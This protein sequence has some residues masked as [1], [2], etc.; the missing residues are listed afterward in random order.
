MRWDGERSEESAKLVPSQTY[1]L[2]CPTKFLSIHGYRSSYLI[3]PIEVRRSLADLS[4][5]LHGDVSTSDKLF[6]HRIADLMLTEGNGALVDLIKANFE[7]L[8][9]AGAISN[10]VPIESGF[11]LFAAI[12]KERSNFLY[13]DQRS[14][15]LNGY[16]DHIRINLINEVAINALI[17]Q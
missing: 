17:T 14:F 6:T 10:H 15:E 8:K 13:L 7:R 11:F 5:N 3:V 16:P 1:R 9:N 12:S 4:L 2:V